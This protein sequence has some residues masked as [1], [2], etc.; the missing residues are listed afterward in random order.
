VST[1]PPQLLDSLRRK[2]LSRAWPI[3][4]ILCMLFGLTALY[5]Q[6]RTLE[7]EGHYQDIVDSLL[8][9]R[10]LNAVLNEQV[11][12]VRRHQHHDYDSLTSAARELDET[13]NTLR[14]QSVYMNNQQIHSLLDQM[15]VLLAE[16]KEVIEQFKSKNA[17]LKNSLRFFPHA[18]DRAVEDARA[19]YWLSQE[20]RF[21]LS[22]AIQH[23]AH[24][25]LAY[26]LTNDIDLLPAIQ[27]RINQIRGMLPPEESDFEIMGRRLLAHTNL[28]LNN[29]HQINKLTQ[30][31][32]DNELANLSRTLEL[33]YIQAQQQWL[34]RRE[35]AR[36]I[37]YFITIM[38]LGYVGYMLKQ[39]RS[40]RRELRN[41]LTQLGYQKFAL[42]QHAIV[43]ITDADG[44]ITYANNHFIE[45]TGFKREEVLG[46]KH[47][48][49]KSGIHPP[50][51][52][53]ELWK[54]ITS[55]QVWHGEICNKAKDG[56]LHWMEAT[57]VPFLDDDGVPYQ[58]VGIRTDITDRRNAEEA[59]FRQKELAHFTLHSIGGGLITTDLEGRVELMNSI[60]EKMTAT[61]LA[62]AQGRALHKSLQIYTESEQRIEKDLT[63]RCLEQNR[64]LA[65][66][67]HLLPLDRNLDQIPVRLFISPIVNRNGEPVG[68]VAVCEDISKEHHLHRQLT[69]Q[70]THDALTGLINRREFEQRLTDAIASNPTENTMNAMLYMD[71]D[72]FKVVNDTC[73]HVAGDQLLKQIA[74]Q[75]R[76]CMRESD[77][78]ARLGGDEFGVLLLNT[79]PPHAQ[80]VAE[81]LLEQVREFR[82]NWKGKVFSIGAS[83][84]LTL[85]DHQDQ[86]TDDVMSSADVACYA[87]KD[88]GRNRVHV[89]QE[90]DHV[91]ASRQGEMQWVEKIQNA[92]DED[93]L[94]L[95]CQ[96]ITATDQSI[97]EAPHYEVLLRLLD[98]S[99]QLAAPGAFL[100]A[101]ERYDLMPAIDRCV[102]RQTF[103][104]LQNYFDSCGNTALRLSINLSGASFNDPEFSRFL[105]DSFAKHDIPAEC[106][107]FEI[108]ETL[109]IQNLEY[110]K[111]FIN[112]FR[113][114][115]CSF[116]L[117]DFGS[118]LSSF[119]YLKNLP[120]DYLKIDGAFVRDMLSDPIDQAMIDTI[121]QVSHLLGRKTIAEWVE[122][123]DTAE[124]LSRMGI[125]YLQGYAIHRP[126]PL[127]Q[128]LEMPAAESAAQN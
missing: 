33:A 65:F 83:I 24:E 60:A 36:L 4:I 101:A 117:D 98:H 63:Q 51:F 70:A 114:L 5:L 120:V 61:T 74:N 53:T 108:T 77:T 37:M 12:R 6:T 76:S 118:G 90:A 52:Y 109:A 43:S 95:Y 89:Y 68:T 75:L 121:N 58:Y 69:H 18:I 103:S 81:K 96:A 31:L 102:V 78:L 80:A 57:I 106:I 11:L 10:H 47:N 119:G 54:T 44:Y 35:K 1:S 59:L 3:L 23:L 122:N 9:V 50:E 48:F 73:G 71:L 27:A 92:L 30:Q 88:S 111:T 14:I 7:H 112:K 116:S 97:E 94:I 45:A 85:I 82:F 17:L 29:K 104:A 105:L 22:D 72:Q 99:G 2:Q 42:D 46:H 64:T 32:L 13:L 123:V 49:L 26:N 84:G 39:L 28:I 126:V 110:A 115:G 66:E 127:Q 91:T 86:S 38:L 87:A 124:E 107:C 100:P 40:R 56:S 16:K 128:A 41:T 55:G 62:Q 15:K 34:G 113:E 8:H 25:T 93:R 19:S 21:T 125:D 20:N 79:T 67:A